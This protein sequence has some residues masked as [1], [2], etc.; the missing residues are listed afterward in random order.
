MAFHP[1]RFTSEEVPA[2]NSD[3]EEE[4]VTVKGRKCKRIKPSFI[5]NNDE[6][7]AQATKKFQVVSRAFTILSTPELKEA[8]DSTGNPLLYFGV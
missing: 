1:D 5:A 3:E 6:M 4:D 7:K 8:Y 2:L